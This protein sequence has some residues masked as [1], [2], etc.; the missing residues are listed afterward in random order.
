M[1]FL[2]NQLGVTPPAA[3]LINLPTFNLVQSASPTAPTPQLTDGASLP[4]PSPIPIQTLPVN[5]ISSSLT[6]NLFPLSAAVHAKIQNLEFIDMAELKPTAWR[7]S[8]P[9]KSNPLLPRKREPVTDIL[10]WVQ[11][12]ATLTA[13]LAEKYPNKLP[14]LLAYQNT[15]VRCA[16]KYQGLNWALYDIEYR[17]KAAVTKSLDWGIIDQSLYAE[18]FTGSSNPA[19]LCTVCLGEHH[20]NSCPQSATPL[21]LWTPSNQLQPP[22]NNFAA[23]PM[24][25]KPQYHSPFVRARQM[26][27]HFP[28][29]AAPM[30]SNL[31][32]NPAVNDDSIPI[33]G[34][35]NSLYGNRCDIPG[36][37]FRHI[38][39]NC[40]GT[41]G[42]ARP[43]CRSF[44]N[45]PQAASLQLGP[46]PAK[47]F[48]GRGRG[49]P[50][51]RFM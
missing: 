43:Y 48:R 45:R 7:V 8:E 37:N 30:L 18:R 35:F 17:Q 6:S 36:C 16:Q 33:C 21:V 5:T 25:L 29:A 38:C 11:C 10:I 24:P 2:G 44:A 50:F 19:P 23:Q 46:P 40:G 1:H 15:I 22:T 14:H 13:I 4:L 32:G 34:K 27:S 28:P 42:H 26:A 49:R 47:R 20:S 41:D 39:S 12:Y 3:S 51:G 31:N 9:E